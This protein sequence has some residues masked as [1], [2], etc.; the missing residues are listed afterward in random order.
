MFKALIGPSPA[1]LDLTAWLLLPSGAISFRE[2]KMLHRR[3]KCQIKFLIHVMISS[4]T[5][6]HLCIQQMQDL[7][8]N[9]NKPLDMRALCGQQVAVSAIS[10]VAHDAIQHEAENV[11][12]FMI[13]RVDGVWFAQQLELPFSGPR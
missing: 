12:R 11:Y 6:T 3:C 8:E 7:A 4:L 2:T 1:S 5:D 10:C 9:G 13:S